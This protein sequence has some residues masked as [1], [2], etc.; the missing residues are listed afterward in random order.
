[1]SNE[2]LPPFREVVESVELLQKNL[3]DLVDGV[4]LI[5]DTQN[6]LSGILIGNDKF[7]QKGLIETVNGLVAAEEETKL[8]KAKLTIIVVIA[9]FVLNLGTQY[10]IARVTNATQQTTSK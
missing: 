9:I 2:S 3:K 5:S 1:M 10:F 8:Q 7:K 4:K 6:Q